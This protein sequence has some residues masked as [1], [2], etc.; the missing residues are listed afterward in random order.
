MQK[1]SN[2]AHVSEQT[3]ERHLSNNRIHGILHQVVK[4]R[5]SG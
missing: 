1:F 3:N 2:S 5:K 4:S